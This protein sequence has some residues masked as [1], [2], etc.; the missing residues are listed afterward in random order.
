MKVLHLSSYYITNKLYMN[1]FKQLSTEGLEQHVF[2]P[3]KSSGSIGVN[4]LPAENKTVHYHF[5][6]MIK[7]HD[8]F[9]FFHKINK[10]M[11]EIEKDILSQNQIDIIHAHTIFSDGGCAYKIHKKYNIDYV[12]SVRSTDINFFYKY[13]IHLRPFMYKVLLN[14]KNVVFI[15]DAYQKRCSNCCLTKCFIRLKINV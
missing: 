14:A 13:G 1:L 8:K 12:V 6:H 9:L 4:Q 11:K 15:S 2:I 7:P 5:K 3:V 10:Q